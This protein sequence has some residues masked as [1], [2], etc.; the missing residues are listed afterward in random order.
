MSTPTNA[1]PAAPAANTAPQTTPNTA[2]AENL[3]ATESEEDAS[4]EG[5]ES[6]E[7]ASPEKKE[8]TPSTKAAVKKALKQLK[9]KVDGKEITEDL[10]FEI[11]DDPKAVEWMQRQLQMSKMGQ[12]RAQKLSEYEKQ[13]TSFFEKLQKD[14]KAALS[15]PNIGVDIKQL[16]RQV[17]EEEIANSQKS[18]EQLEREKLEKE[19]KAL[20]EQQQK[21][22]EEFEKREFERLQEAAYEQYDMQID[23]ALENSG[24]PKKPYVVKKFAEYM[25]L[26]LQNGIDVT[27]QDILPL[28]KEEIEQD[29]KEM[30]GASP[31]EVVEQFIGKEKLNSIRKKKV[32]KAKAEQPPMPLAKSLKDA[33]A[34]KKE[35]T[36]EKPQTYRDFFKV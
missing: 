30:I 7:A 18:P 15:D 10:P 5:E 6:P 12:S 8:S 27:P 24:L 28:V 14:P 1:A 16:A 3:E 4:A 11:P 25:L 33:G 20:K 26:G 9:L 2:P 31:D 19:I 29:I 35:K 32:A 22:K 17:I 34:P 23:K 13:V 21:E 36:P